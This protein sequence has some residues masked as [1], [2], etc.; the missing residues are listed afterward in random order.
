MGAIDIK[1][2]KVFVVFALA[3]ACVSA[4]SI[5][6]IPAFLEDVEDVN[7]IEGRITNGNA[8]AVGQFPYQ[9]GLSLK[10]SSGSFWCG[11]SLIGNQWILTAAHCTDGVN[12]VT[13]YLGST[14]RTVAKVSHTVTSS[15]I[16][17]HSGYNSNTLANDI[18]LIKI[19]TV[20]YTAEIKAI[21]LPAISSS[22]STY[23][24]DYA[25]A[26]GWGRAVDTGSVVSSLNYARLQVI[27]NT[28][29]AANYGN[30]IVTDKTICVSTTGGTSTCQGDSG[31]PLALE[32]SQLLIGVTSFVSSSGCQAG[33][34]SGFI[35][36]TGYLDWI[37]ANTGIA[38]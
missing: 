38:Y 31:G 24:G 11:G 20:S 18:S 23:A 14:V 22:Y 15:S 16:Y 4:A 36:V 19:P 37:K 27:S 12:S 6:D 35:R 17:Q 8:A 9:A 7:V 33:R 26:S 28:V 2:M 5:P 29:C 3:L 25:I 30:S 13:V 32:S 1:A 10:R 34:P 21:R